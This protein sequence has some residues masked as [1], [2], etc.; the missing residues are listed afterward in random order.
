MLKI[1]LK[2]I[3]QKFLSIEIYVSIS[4]LFHYS[5]GSR[6]SDR[7]VKILMGSI[8]DNLH[9]NTLECL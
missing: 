5:L 1:K 8:E 4:T 3:V 6:F 2:S 9:N 7:Q